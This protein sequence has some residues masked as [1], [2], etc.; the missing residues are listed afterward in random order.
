MARSKKY[1]HSIELIAE[2]F[3]YEDNDLDE[4]K[5]DAKTLTDE[6]I[7]GIRNLVERHKETHD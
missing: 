1:A 5:K 7:V 6:Q 2:Y 3:G 4:W